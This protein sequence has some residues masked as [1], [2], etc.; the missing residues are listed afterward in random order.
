MSPRTKLQT[1]Q[2]SPALL[3][4]PW[5]GVYD[6]PDPFDAGP[7]RLRD[8]LNAYIPDPQ[9]GSGVYARNGFALGNNGNA[10]TTAL[11]NLFGQAVYAHTQLD[12]SIINFV[13]CDGKLLTIAALTEG[14]MTITD[15][16]PVGITIQSGSPI[17]VFITSMVKNVGGV[18]Q[19]VIVVNDGV[20]RPWFGTNLTS[21][22]ITGTAIDYDGA[23]HAWSAFGPPVVWQGSVFFVLRSVNGVN[24]NQDIAWSE[25][26]DPST[27]YQQTNFD[28]NMTLV[29]HS[30]GPLFALAATNAALYYFRGESIGVIYGGIANL[31]TT[32]TQDAV[33]VNV[34]C[35][36]PAT[37]QQFG[38]SFL[39]CD[40]LLRPYRFTPGSTPE[41]IWHQM[42][43]VTAAHGSG[44]ADQV[45]QYATSAIEPT[46]NLYLVLLWRDNQGVATNH[47]PTVL[48]V[49]DA[50]S[51]TY[52]GRWTVSDSGSGGIGIGPMGLLYGPDLHTPT[53]VF[54]GEKQAGTG[55]L[56][57]LWYFRVR[58]HDV[59]SHQWQDANFTLSNYRLPNV[60]VKTDRLGEQ[61]DVVYVVDR[62]TL[63][64]GNAAACTVTVETPTTSGTVIGTPT[65]SVSDDET[66]RLV[67]GCEGVQGR[68]PSVTVAPSGTDTSAEQ[69]SLQR[70][71]VAVMAS[72]AGPEDP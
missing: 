35:T 44:W 25:P 39:F 54:L 8:A 55:T 57:F 16:T 59:D 70:V 56:G 22:P 29:Q 45:V 9:V 1:V 20:N 49:F 69:W 72:L 31:A 3:S 71:S 36:V 43:A 65:A 46:Y 28:N 37:I 32:N 63:L 24:R 30:T 2:R 21:T 60:Q 7:D 15:V 41:P 42:R 12:G 64:T 61:E 53:L 11:D 38:S 4:G 62:V 40:A 68:G 14:P 66:H 52:L 50:G 48:Y 47:L 27:G 5:K 17:P 51:G 6:T 58:G 13:I 18:T 67:V 10:V 34:G 26:G 19:S 23:G 33:S